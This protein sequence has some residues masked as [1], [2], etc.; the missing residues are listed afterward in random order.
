MLTILLWS[1]D[2]TVARRCALVPMATRP[3]RRA[4]KCPCEGARA[5]SVWR[6]QNAVN[7]GILKEGAFGFAS[8]KGKA[9]FLSQGSAWV[10]PCLWRL[11]RPS[12][13][14]LL[15]LA[16]HQKPQPKVS[17]GLLSRE[18]WTENLSPHR[19]RIDVNMSPTRCFGMRCLQTSY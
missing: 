12:S 3:R 19:S 13:L 17:I 6:E 15:A 10:G 5:T 7:L 2:P 14:G 8:K 11:W 16:M 4:R 18:I 9:G 1:C